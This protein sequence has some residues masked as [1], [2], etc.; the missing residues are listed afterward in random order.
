MLIDEKIIEC[1]LEYI[2]CFS[3]FYENEDIIR[4][5]DN[6]LED[7][8]YHN[9]TYIKK[10]MSEIELKGIIENEIML[11][12]SQKSNFCNIIIN[13]LVNDSLLAML[14]Y[15]PQISRNGYYSFDLTKFTKLNTQ[16]GCTIRKVNN[17]EMV[18]DIL[19]CD[20]QHN[21]DKLGKDFCTRRCYRRGKVYISDKGVNSYVCYYEGDIIGNCDL[22]IHKGVAK[23]EDFA[24]IPIHQRKGYGTT[25]LKELISFAIKKNSHTVYLVTDE[26]DTAK[27][28][29]QK[30]GFNKIGERTDL[31]FDLT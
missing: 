21:E 27:E 25:I 4:F 19:F 2:K 31:F 24:V 22:F 8:Y 29:Y 15:E 18:E 30:I 3:K 1:E 17:K 5:Y 6:Q 13:S 12:L 10:A 16:S 14:K 28:M 26:D 7:M 9:Y 20:L 11:R 23:I